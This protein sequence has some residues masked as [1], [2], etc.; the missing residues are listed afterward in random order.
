[1]DD[2]LGVSECIAQRG[3]IGGLTERNWIYQ[4]RPR[5]GAAQ[6]K[7]VGTLAVTE[8]VGTFGVHSDWPGSGVQRGDGSLQGCRSAD[9]GWHA[10]RRRGEQLRL[11][12]K[13]RSGKR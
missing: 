8:S 1:V 11:L 12:I 4:V 5:S 3:E 7:E 6:L 10:L 9:D 2:P 13:I